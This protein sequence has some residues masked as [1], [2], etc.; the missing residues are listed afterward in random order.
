VR[1]LAET[2]L[3]AAVRDRIADAGSLHHVLE[4]VEA[5]VRRLCADLTE[6]P[7]LELPEL[8]IILLAAA[9]WFTR[10]G[11]FPHRPSLLGVASVGN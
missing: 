8:W 11:L 6:I 5:E 9:T 4:R 3:I 2:K 1:R 7:A 10:D